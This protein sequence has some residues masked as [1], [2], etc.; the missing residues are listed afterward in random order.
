MASYRRHLARV[1]V[2]LTL[3]AALAQVA[4]P[5][6]GAAEQTEAELVV[7]TALA[8]RG[9]QWV[10][11]AKGPNKFDCSGLV[12]YAFW[13][14]GLAETKI[15]R[16]RSVSGY[17]KWFKDQGRANRENPQLGDLVVWGNN[18]HIGIYIGEGMAVSTLVTRRGVSVH[19]V[20]G[21]LNVAFKVYLH[22]DL[23]RPS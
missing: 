11:R 14:H 18:Q 1:A 17:V 15:G 2:V 12:W 3:V 4:V 5:V 21:Y 23:T 9:D 16:Y 10:H 7:A 22:T 6:A 19:P 20:R 13:K 8:Q